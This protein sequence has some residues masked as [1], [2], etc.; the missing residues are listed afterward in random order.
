MTL[1]QSEIFQTKLSELQQA[2]LAPLSLGSAFFLHYLFFVENEWLWKNANFGKHSMTKRKSK[3]VT[4]LWK[5]LWE[6]I[7]RVRLIV[8]Y[9]FQ[10]IKLTAYLMTKTNKNK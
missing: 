3:S 7:L 6:M 4:V 8:Y 2:H 10:F 9:Q 1:Q 5:A